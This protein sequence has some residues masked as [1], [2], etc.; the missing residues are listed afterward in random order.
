MRL[1]PD[2]MIEVEYE[3]EVDRTGKATKYRIDGDD[4]WFPD[5]VI[6]DDDGTYIVVPAKLV[7]EKELIDET[8][9]EQLREEFHRTW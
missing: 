6:E 5:S 4:V 8:D 7:L 2:G 9:L 3:L 1:L